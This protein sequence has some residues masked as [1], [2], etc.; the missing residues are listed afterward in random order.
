MKPYSPFRVHTIVINWSNPIDW[1]RIDRFDDDWNGGW[2]YITRS[3]YKSD[4]V[5]TTP[6]YIGKSMNKI[7]KR[8]LS[9]KLN[10]SET[11]FLSEYGEFKVRFGRVVSPD[12][13][14]KRFHFNR[15]LLTVESAL[16]TE[17]QPKSN[18]S[19]TQKYTRWYKLVIINKGKHDQIPRV[20]DN[21]AHN[22]V[23][24]L[25]EWWIGQHASGN[26]NGPKCSPSRA[27]GRRLRTLFLETV[28]N[29]RPV[30]TAKSILKS[31]DI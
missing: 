19:Q 31:C 15:F 29:R 21:R 16:I 28:L 8:I 1:D 18:R 4:A 20:I 7:S 23:R 2:Y 25:P 17:V 3:I 24:R 13:Y 22:N 6:I 30:E 11:P 27:A 5:Y 12:Y 26:E 9:H 10:D 14:W